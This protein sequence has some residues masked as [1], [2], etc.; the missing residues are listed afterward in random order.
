MAPSPA[1]EWVSPI[2]SELITSK[3]LKLSSPTFDERGSLY[4]LEG[5]PIEGGRTVVVSW[6]VGPGFAGW[7]QARRGAGVE[8]RHLSHPRYARPPLVAASLHTACTPAQ[9]QAAVCL[10]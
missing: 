4:F 5:R 10:E 6:W 3:T 8:L 2:T 7:M 9:L 1:G